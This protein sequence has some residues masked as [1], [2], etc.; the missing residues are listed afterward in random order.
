[1]SVQLTSKNGQVEN[2]ICNGSWAALIALARAYEGDKIPN[3]NGC[4]DGY[5]WTPEQLT[6]IADRLHQTAELE[7]MIR[8]MAANGGVKIT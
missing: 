3:W 4:H 7:E 2:N 6:L 8:E 5:E 1:M